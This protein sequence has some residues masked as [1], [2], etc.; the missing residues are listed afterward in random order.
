MSSYKTPEERL[1]SRLAPLLST[2]KS[3]VE[4]G[5]WV[6]EDNCL[7]VQCQVGISKYMVVF[8]DGWIPQVYR[9][10]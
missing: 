3:K 2:K 4:I 10:V 1:Q 9:R 7:I 5:G 8:K 6:E